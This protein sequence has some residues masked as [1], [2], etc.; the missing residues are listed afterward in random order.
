MTR[1]DHHGGAAVRDR[2]RWGCRL[3]RTAAVATAALGLVLAAQ[4]TLTG[5]V[6]RYAA[7]LVGAVAIATLAAAW[8][9]WAGCSFH[10][11]LAT[12]GLAG[13][14][15]AGEVLVSSL[16]GPGGP[17][18][19]WHLDGVAVAVLAVIVLLLAAAAPQPPEP[20]RH[21]YAL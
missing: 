7:A 17:A 9:M 11:R 20:R 2:H 8:R 1:G 10:V 3:S 4:L 5:S 14:I 13:A 18:A 15:L 21:P 16:G 12:G 19:R 6:E